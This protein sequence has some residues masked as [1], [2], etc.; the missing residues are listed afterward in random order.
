MLIDFWAIL[1]F[2]VIVLL[3]L[4]LFSFNKISIKN[5][6]ETQFE[7]KDANFMLQSFLRAPALGPSV[8]YGTKT[9]ADIIAEDDA[10]ND[11]GRT[12]Q[13]FDNYFKYSSGASKIRVEVDGKNHDSM[14]INSKIS[15]FTKVL[16]W[17]QGMVIPK[18]ETYDA[19]TYI[20]GYDGRINVKLKKEESVKINAG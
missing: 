20:P 1:I 13:L 5:S 9:V 2:A 12:E 14:V 10:K 15:I 19:E 6:I 4:I 17:R 18:G 16:L 11:F 7:N 8:G 3:F